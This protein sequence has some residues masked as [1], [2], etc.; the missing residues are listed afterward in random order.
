MLLTHL[1][2]HYN[3]IRWIMRCISSISFAVLTNG[4]TSC[5]FYLERGLCEGYPLSPLLFLLVAEG[6]SH[7]LSHAKS[8][9]SFRGLEITHTLCIS[10]FLFVD[11][12]LSFYYGTRRDLEYM[13]QGLKLIKAA[14]GMVINEDKSMIVMAQIDPQEL[15]FLLTRFPFPIKNS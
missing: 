4:S 13:D 12:I 1:G 6:L 11:D 5:F 14:A 8:T 3:F 2:F 9:G 7:F 15:Q 10:H